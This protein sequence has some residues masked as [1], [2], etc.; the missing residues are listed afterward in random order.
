[1]KGEETWGR[2]R[3]KA[4]RSAVPPANH[5]ANLGD[6]GVIYSKGDDHV[7]DAMRCAML[8]RSIRSTDRPKLS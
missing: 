8:R 2:S 4:R 7:V 5:A 1:M 3:S 6:R